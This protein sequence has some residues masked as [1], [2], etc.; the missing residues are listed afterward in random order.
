MPTP[1]GRRPEPRQIGPLAV[2][3][4]AATVLLVVLGAADGGRNDTVSRSTAGA[5]AAAWSGFV[6]DERVQVAL[7]QRQIVVLKAPSLA[8][9]VAAHG[10]QVGDVQERRWA[11]AALAGQRQLIQRL[12]LQ[13]IAVHPDFNFGRVLNGFSAALDPRATALLERMPEVHGLYPVRAVYPASV[14]PGRGGEPTASAS[15]SLRLSLPGV[16]GRGITIA[17]L[18]TGVDRVH[19]LVAGHV[20]AGFDVVDGDERALAESRPGD[21]TDIERHGTEL[22]G[23]ILADGDV[24]RG[25]A[26]GAS[27]IPLRV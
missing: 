11:R 23:L 26:P 9:R 1:P 27:V 14:P 20:R 13:G 15:G 2:V 21:P 3:A 7:G 22:A 25:V 19:P 12:A 5:A 17:L 18:D 8:E 24:V 16:T 10:G 6:G 4:L